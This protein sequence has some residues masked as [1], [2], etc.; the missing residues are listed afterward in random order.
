MALH[1]NYLSINNG[2]DPIIAFYYL[3]TDKVR[4]D[5][6]G[7]FVQIFL[8]F[9]DEIKKTQANIHLLTFMILQL[10]NWKYIKKQE[11]VLFL[12]ND[13]DNNGISNKI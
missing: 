9:L 6:F 5:N 4:E 1:N 11:E 12:N 10:K 13:F 3:N 7:N 8:K 2:S